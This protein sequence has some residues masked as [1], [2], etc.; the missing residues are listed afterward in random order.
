M[1]KSQ[2]PEKVSSQ[3]DSKEMREIRKKIKKAE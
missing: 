3:M 2:S 1:P